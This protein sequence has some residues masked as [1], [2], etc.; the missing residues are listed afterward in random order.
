MRVA[1]MMVVLMPLLLAGRNT[2]AK[3][4]INLDISAVATGETVLKMP[5]ATHAKKIAW[6]PSHHV[7]AF[8]GDKAPQQEER[9]RYGDTSRS[10]YPV[11]GT[12]MQLPLAQAGVWGLPVPAVVQQRRGRA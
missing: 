2:A 5:I 1:M 3:K 4:M 8:A 10:E 9:A 6:H 7:L 12:R 11:S